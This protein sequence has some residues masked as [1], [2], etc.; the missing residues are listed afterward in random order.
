MIALTALTN[1]GHSKSKKNT[2]K[3]NKAEARQLWVDVG[4][5]V[6]CRAPYISGACLLQTFRPK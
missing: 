1:R 6:F 5:P 3:T 4:Q 2:I